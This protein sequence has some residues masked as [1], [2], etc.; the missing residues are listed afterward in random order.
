MSM[1][2][3]Y[4]LVEIQGFFSF[5]FCGKNL[6]LIKKWK[7]T[8]ECL[9][10]IM[11]QQLCSNFHPKDEYFQTYIWISMNNIIPRQVSLTQVFKFAL[12]PELDFLPIPW[13]FT[14]LMTL[15]SFQAAINLYNYLLTKHDQN[16]DIRCHQHRIQIPFPDNTGFQG[17]HICHMIRIRISDMT[18][19]A[20]QTHSQTQIVNRPSVPLIIHG[21]NYEN[22]VHAI[23]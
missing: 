4:T 1:N 7:K 11:I 6:I 19:T 8:F 13:L 3:E 17:H 5:F 22:C 15:V 16:I 14:T 12:F 21:R 18:Y 23:V 9:A 2:N 10:K 20:L